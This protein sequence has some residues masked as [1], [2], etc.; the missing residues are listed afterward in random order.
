MEK[1]ECRLRNRGSRSIIRMKLRDIIDPIIKLAEDAAAAEKYLDECDNQFA[2]RAYI[3]S[4]F[5]F[6]EA[7]VW[8][9]KK[10]CVRILVQPG[11]GPKRLSLAECAL[12]QDQTYELRNN[13]EP[14][15]RTKNLRLRDNLRF[16]FKIFNRISGSKIDPGVGTRSW[17]AF[18]RAV[19]IRNRITH[20]K[21]ASDMIIAD[22]EIQTCKEV[23]SWFNRMVAA[24]IEELVEASKR[25]AKGL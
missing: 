11:S 13:G 7:T 14:S 21:S 17:D 8:L 5:A 23:L 25:G 20:P 2:R 15:V 6:L 4:L 16:T 10:V 1:P 18:M 19:A 3:R 24:S 9:L 22:S 12:L